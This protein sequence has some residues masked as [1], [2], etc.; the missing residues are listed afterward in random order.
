MTKHGDVG[1]RRDSDTG[2]MPQYVIYPA[3]KKNV[4]VVSGQK[5]YRKNSHTKSSGSLQHFS[6]GINM[7][8]TK[9]LTVSQ[10]MGNLVT[11]GNE[12]KSVRKVKKTSRPKVMKV[13]HSGSNLRSMKNLSISTASLKR[14]YKHQVNRHHASQPRLVQG[15]PK[16]IKHYCK[17]PR[18]TRVSGT[19]VT[20]K[21]KSSPDL[22]DQKRSK[23]VYV[24]T[25]CDVRCKSKFSLKMHMILHMFDKKNKVYTCADCGQQFQFKD[26]LKKHKMVH[27]WLPNVNAHLQPVKTKV[28]SSSF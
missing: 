19:S 17:K 6:D 11:Q 12:Q 28:K 9:K 27:S 10:S 14:V 15:S 3:Y 2:S 26:S 21:S 18:N 7:E 25:S 24:C 22:T 1:T 8:S 13:A 4:K 16:K 5:K 20:T 23:E